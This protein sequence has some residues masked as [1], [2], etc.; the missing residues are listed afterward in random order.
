MTTT[1]VQIGSVA[2]ARGASADDIVPREK[3]NLLRP[4]HAQVYLENRC[5]LR[6]QHCYETPTSHPQGDSLSLEDYDALF[7][8]LAELGVLF[9]TF[10]GG[11]VLLR[12]DALDIVALARRHRFA[13]TL[14]T[15]G[16]LIDAARADRIKALRVS[17]VHVSVYSHEA[18]VHDAFT[19]VPGSH[20]RSLAAL[21]LLRERGVSTVLKANV[22]RFNIDHLDELIALAASFGA[23]IQLDPTVRPRL[24]G[25][26]APLE[27]GV[28]AAE[29]QRKVLVRPE[30]APAFRRH[31]AEELCTGERSLLSDDDVLCGAA[32]DVISIG[33]NGD[34]LAC[35]YFPSPAGRWSR[36]PEG[37]RL[38]DI[39]LGSAQLD[40]IREMN[41]ARMN[42]CS[43]CDL[44]SVC[45][46]CMAFG[47]VEHGDI[48]ACN[49]TSRFGATALG[50]LAAKKAIANR[51]MEHG[52]SLPIV[53]DR[54]VA[55]RPALQARQ[56]LT[57]EP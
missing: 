22:L 16:T 6:C 18:A 48:G 45:N 28:T 19:R 8:E 52:R 25:D 3:W 34:V 12:R 17:E 49:R 27:H 15:S 4:R 1:L 2:N 20:A 11:E 32:R 44:R 56:V 13:V 7:G 40:A 55:V 46:P 30:L 21:E 42:D 54:N 23:A 26:R 57:T 29:L 33:A 24:D 51:K 9:L 39:W 14:Y 50:M 31:R 38:R 10:T 35:G 36:A 37:R 53:G 5:H 43:S 47:E 41:F